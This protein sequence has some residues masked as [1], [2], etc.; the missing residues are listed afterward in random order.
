MTLPDDVTRALAYMTVVEA[1]LHP[2]HSAGL[3]HALVLADF[4]RAQQGRTCD[5]C[6]WHDP[7][8]AENRAWCRHLK[9]CCGTVGNTCG[10]FAAKVDQDRERPM[11]ERR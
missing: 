5:K 1:H 3:G 4:V 8:D 2:M 9:H 11:G 7:A 10:A 6:R